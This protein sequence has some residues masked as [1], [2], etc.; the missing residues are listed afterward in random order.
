[1]I[2]IILDTDFLSS[3]L[4]IGQLELVRDFYQV[5]QVYI[6]PSV[7]REIGK[8]ALL[9]EL[10]KRTWVCIEA[11]DQFIWQDLLTDV[12]FAKL[13]QGEQE[14]IALAKGNPPSQLLISDNRARQ[15]ALSQRIVAS[16]IPAF[17]YAC[18][19]VHLLDR[20]DIEQ[21]IEDLKQKD[22]YEFKQIEKDKL[23]N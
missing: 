12:D 9:M 4:K 8:S 23:L 19:L 6:T 17:L 5:T 18:K 11:A 1:M 22:L 20:N 13:G 10:K 16:N 3:F 7:Y 14:S 2:K 15:F 21:I